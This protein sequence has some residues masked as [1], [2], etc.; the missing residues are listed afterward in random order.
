MV[1]DI[2][3]KRV[4]SEHMCL[5]LIFLFFVIKVTEEE[6]SLFTK[7]NDEYRSKFG[8][9]FILAVRNATKQTVL[10][11]I[12]ARVKNTYEREFA[13]SLAQVHKIQR[14]FL[15]QI[16]RHGVVVFAYFG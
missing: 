7:T 6:Y 4:Y 8:F 3:A 1:H 2:A 12:K 13:A 14:T 5:Y 10:Q 9:P 11:A 16:M 15:V